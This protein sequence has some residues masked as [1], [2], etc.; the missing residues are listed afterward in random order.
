MQIL[1]HFI[2][3]LSDRLQEVSPDFLWGVVSGKCF[4]I[5]AQC[6]TIADW[7]VEQGAMDGKSVHP[8]IES[9]QRRV[10]YG[11]SPFQ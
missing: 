11:F 1:Y 4:P 2:E 6:Q 3:F 10:S 7:T 5:G 9:G 8:E